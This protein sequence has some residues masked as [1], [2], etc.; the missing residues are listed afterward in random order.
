MAT[1]FK[2]PSELIHIE[3]KD[4]Y[5]CDAMGA[6]LKETPSTHLMLY[7]NTRDLLREWKKQMR[8]AKIMGE[9]L[10]ALFFGAEGNP[11]RQLLEEGLIDKTSYNSIIA[12][13]KLLHKE[14]SIYKLGWHEIRIFFEKIDDS[15]RS[16]VE[17]FLSTF[18]DFY[19]QNVIKAAKGYT[20][21][22]FG[23]Y[24]CSKIMRDILRQCLDDEDWTGRLTQEQAKNLQQ[25][26]CPRHLSKIDKWKIFALKI[27]S[28]AA[29]ED[30][31][32]KQAIREFYSQMLSIASSTTSATLRQRKTSLGRHRSTRWK[33]GYLFVNK[34]SKKWIPYHQA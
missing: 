1:F 5:F 29:R 9:T 6:V 18:R 27:C 2:A 7:I 16:E 31:S 20:K 13:T 21:T 8:S 14:F 32:L 28:D 12:I 34:G 19:D 4:Y 3:N 33:D 15:P 30:D 24:K 25:N 22:V 11:P 23:A 10:S 17:L 26:S